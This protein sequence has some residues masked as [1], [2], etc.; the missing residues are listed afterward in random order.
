M[1]N[2]NK[3]IKNPELRRIY[4]D[5]YFSTD[6]EID[7]NDFKIALRFIKQFEINFEDD[8]LLSIESSSDAFLVQY[9]EF[10]KFLRKNNY[11]LNL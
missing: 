1:R 4:L 10:L 9:I 3:K 2:F 8:V 6:I 7:S 11:C 5:Q